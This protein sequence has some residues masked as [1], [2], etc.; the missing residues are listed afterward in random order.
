MTTTP[1]TVDAYIARLEQA[2]CDGKL[3]CPE[4][5]GWPN[6][7]LDL[8]RAYK[9]QKAELAK[10]PSPQPAG[11]PSGLREGNAEL[12]EVLCLSAQLMDAWK[13][14]APEIWSEHDENLRRRVSLCMAALAAPVEANTAEWIIAKAARI[15]REGC[16]V[17]PDGGSPS[18]S[19]V[20]MCE[21]IA[22]AIEAIGKPMPID[23]FAALN[24]PQS[25][26]YE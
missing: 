1:E 7:V 8:A 15:A 26:G 12:R 19:E 17:P 2:V 9:T 3:D 10:L 18:E 11:A 6:V 20:D 25:R 21:G 24:A 22:R 23:E 13:Q 4:N 14:T 16:L 5:G